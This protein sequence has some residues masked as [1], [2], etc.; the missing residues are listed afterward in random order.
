MT[1][2]RTTNTLIVPGPPPLTLRRRSRSRSGSSSSAP[3][4]TS[5]AGPV[6]ATIPPSRT[7]PPA[8]TLPPA[9]TPT[10]VVSDPSQGSRGGLPT[11]MS[12]EELVSQPGRE[13][14]THLDPKYLFVPNTTWFDLSSNGIT[15]SLLRMKNL[16]KHGYPTYCD[17]PD[18]DQ[19]LWF[20]QFAQKFTWDSGLTTTVKNAFHHK[21]ARHY[22]KRIN[23]WKQK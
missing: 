1:N 10:S 22:T 12:I 16:L 18:E 4:N 19:A 8:H 23:E 6:A 7:P 17:M 5:P 14:L 11:V 3:P 13:S 20:R 2:I 21:S 9:R 15:Q